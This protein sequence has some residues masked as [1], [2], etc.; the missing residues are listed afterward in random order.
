MKHHKIKK[1][2]KEFL[3]ALK[4]KFTEDPKEKQPKEFYEIHPTIRAGKKK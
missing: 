4:E 2:Q 3:K 1:K